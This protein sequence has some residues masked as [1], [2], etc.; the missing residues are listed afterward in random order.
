MTLNP[1]VDYFTIRIQNTGH[2]RYSNGKQL[3]DCQMLQILNDIW[4]TLYVGHKAKSIEALRRGGSNI[5]EILI[6]L[7]VEDP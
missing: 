4:R 5:T 7:L 1:K 2:V 6:M 3:F